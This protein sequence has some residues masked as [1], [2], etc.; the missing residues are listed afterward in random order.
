MKV[1]LIMYL[2]QS[3]VPLYP[4]RK[5]LCWIIDSVIDHKINISKYNHLASS[6]HIKLPKDLDIP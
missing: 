6:S 2:N 4:K 5:N 1:T 3:M